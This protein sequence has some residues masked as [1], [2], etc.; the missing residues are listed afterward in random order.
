MQGE[1]EFWYELASHLHLP[2]QQCKQQTTSREFVRWRIYLDKSYS[3]PTKEDWLFANLN[4]TILA[5]HGKKGVRIK[6]CLV[7]FEPS[8]EVNKPKQTIEQATQ[9]SKAKWLQGLGIVES[10]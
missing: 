9:G 2:V 8:L 4:A 6:D 5:A 3:R 10:K 7:T 1:E